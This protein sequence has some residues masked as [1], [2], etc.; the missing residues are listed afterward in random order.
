MLLSEIEDKLYIHQQTM[1]DTPEP[2]EIL[3]A[4]IT[5]FEKNGK[6]YLV[7]GYPQMR[8]Y[9]N[10]VLADVI[11]ESKL[12]FRFKRVEYVPL[13]KIPHHVSDN[14]CQRKQSNEEQ[15]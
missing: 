2:R 4:L 5:V 1:L 8:L 6:F 11:C 10:G 13:H 14:L 15:I 3:E 7:E 12:L 9:Q